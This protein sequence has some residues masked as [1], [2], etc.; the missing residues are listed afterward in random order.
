MH[1]MRFLKILVVFVFYAFKVQAQEVKDFTLASVT[2]NS[3]FTLSQS[4]GKMVALHFLLKTECPYCIR[5]TSEYFEKAS[6]LPNLV[7]VFIKPDDAK[8]IKAWANKLAEKTAA[9][10]PIYQDLNAT[11]ADQ[12][13]IPNG[14]SFHGQVVHYPA[15]ILLNEKGEEVYRYVGKSNTD[16]FSFESLKAKLQELNNKH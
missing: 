1:T 13:K 2:D 7:Q 9:T 14:Y 12:Y 4:K 11:L 10:Y 8:E 6:T 3:S 15:L 5:H 16:R